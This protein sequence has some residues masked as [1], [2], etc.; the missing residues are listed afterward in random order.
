MM[1]VHPAM[2]ADP[3]IDRHARRATDRHLPARATDLAGSPSVWWRDIWST[4]Y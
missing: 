4:I 3:A 1:A 2:K